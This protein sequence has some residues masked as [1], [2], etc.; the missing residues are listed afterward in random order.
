MEC[1][2]CNWLQVLVGIGAGA[3]I[4]FLLKHYWIPEPPFTCVLLPHKTQNLCVV[5][6][7]YFISRTF[8]FLSMKNLFLNNVL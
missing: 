7:P 3:I 2:E 6:I 8:K 4:A 5:T 1:P